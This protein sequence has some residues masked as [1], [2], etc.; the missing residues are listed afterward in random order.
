MGKIKL[1]Y[2]ATD[3]HAFKFYFALY[4]EFISDY[5]YSNVNMAADP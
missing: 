2:R 4:T 5:G 1:F 3:L